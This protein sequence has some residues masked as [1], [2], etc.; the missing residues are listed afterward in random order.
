MIRVGIDIGGTKVNIGLVA[1]DGK[2][3]AKENFPVGN[4]TDMKAF[5]PKLHFMGS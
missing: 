3:L 1:E 2:V 4:A 5:I